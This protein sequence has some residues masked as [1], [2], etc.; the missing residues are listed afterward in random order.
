MALRRCGLS[1]VIILAGFVRILEAQDQPSI[2]VETIIQRLVA[3]ET[4]LQRAFG[5]YEFR[6]DVTV[7]ELDQKDKVLGEYHS[8]SQVRTD[9]AGQ[10]TERVLQAPPNTL[11]RVAISPQDLQDIRD[12]QP[13]PITSDAITKYDIKY[14][15]KED[16]LG[17]HCYVFDVKPKK[18]EK[19]Q[20]Y[21]EGK[22]W[23]ENS[24]FHMVKTFGKSVPD[25]REKSGGEDL[26]PRFESFRAE[27]DGYWFPSQ[28]QA[29]DTLHFSNGDVRIRQVVRYEDYR[30]MN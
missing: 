6:R 30:K 26:F 23:V 15:G 14:G 16:I 5:S 13:F 24:D 19:G 12:T 9:S 18:T 28:S 17:V 8:V 10:R 7:Q 22:L 2:P 25:I 21:F 29:V 20:R 1:L 3:R 11:K 27:I 4:E